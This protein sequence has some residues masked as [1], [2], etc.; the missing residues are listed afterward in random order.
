[1]KAME[2][3]PRLITDLDPFRPVETILL[4]KSN[5]RDRATTVESVS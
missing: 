3:H 5:R 4:W 2:L 1:M